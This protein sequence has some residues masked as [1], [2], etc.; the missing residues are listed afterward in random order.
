MADRPFNH[1]SCPTHPSPRPPPLHLPSSASTPA[2]PL[3]P[4][5]AVLG[6]PPHLSMRPLPPSL[7]PR[8]HPLSRSLSTLCLPAAASVAFLP[9]SLPPSPLPH[10]TPRRPLPQDLDPEQGAAWREGPCAHQP[11]RGCVR[12]SP[13]VAQ[14]TEAATSDSSSATSLG[15]RLRAGCTCGSRL[16]CPDERSGLTALTC[17]GGRAP[18]ARRSG[19][20]GQIR[21]R[22]SRWAWPPRVQSAMR[23]MVGR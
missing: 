22:V 16:C 7:A 15:V 21:R 5:P 17:R 19:D 12:D 18:P 4:S 13:T 14:S 8:R 11:W 20:Q 10:P 2:R 6:P 23:S 3:P 1:R 9:L